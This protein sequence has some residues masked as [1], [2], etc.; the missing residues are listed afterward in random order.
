VIRSSGYILTNNH[1]I[2]IAAT[3]GQ[4]S[5]LFSDG[6]TAPAVI[7]GRDPKADLAVIKVDGEPALPVIPFGSSAS[8]VVGQPVV[9][10]GAPLG[11]SNTVTSGI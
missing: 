3:G 10:L 11:L 1:V 7:T 2:S 6:H 4:V 8:V 5:V 9:A